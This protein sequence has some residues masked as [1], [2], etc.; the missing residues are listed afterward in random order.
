MP[1][2]MP[3]YPAAFHSEVNFCKLQLRLSRII[4]KNIS[5]IILTHF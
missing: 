4:F 3:I 5:G 2:F 1:I